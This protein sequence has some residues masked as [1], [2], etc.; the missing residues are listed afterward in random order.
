MMRIRTALQICLFLA[1]VLCI[2]CGKSSTAPVD[3]GPPDTPG[4]VDIEPEP[5]K[6]LYGVVLDDAGQ[7]VP[8]VVV[9]DGYASTTTDA[10][11]IYQLKRDSDADFVFYSTPSDYAINVETSSRNI[12][13]FYKAISVSAGEAFRADFELLKLPASESDFTL[14]CIGDPQVTNQSE[15][16]RFQEETVNDLKETLASLSSP[17]YGLS[18]GDVVGDQQGLLNTMKNTLGSTS[19]PVFTTIGNHDKFGSAPAPKSG[20]FFSGIYG[21]LNYSFNRGEVHFICL[22]NVVFSDNSSYAAALSDDQIDWITED[23]SYVPKD[24]MVI[25]YFHIPIRGSGVP[26]KDRLL[27]LFEGYAE[28]HFMSGHTHYNQNYIH[29]T[30]SPSIYEHIH[31]AACGAW[32]RSTINGDGTPNGYAVYDISGNSI[33]SWYYKAVNYDRDFQLRLHWGDASFGGQYGYFSFSQPG[34][35]LVA[36]VWNADEEWMLEVY[37]DGVKTGDMK[38]ASVSRDAWSMGYHIGVLNRNPNNYSQL[39]DHL[40]TYLPQ[41]PAAVIK[42]VATDRFGNTYEQA[43]ITSD[44]EPAISY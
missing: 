1:A 12:P 29:T 31:G 5:G 38:P 25:V 44:F 22:D 17:A 14:F 23:L 15:V 40:Y 10:A 37:E 36:N 24:K 16:T 20:D 26:N 33:K 13:A 28:V 39:C 6:D 34:N 2:D 4:V 41:N 8:G 7:P 30:V 3:N 27:K 19:M 11:G 21:P 35:T 32:W 43:V 42:V 18:M 9:S